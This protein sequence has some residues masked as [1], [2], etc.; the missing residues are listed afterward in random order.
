MP[1]TPLPE[2]V[3]RLHSITDF[4]DPRL[5]PYRNM[6]LQ[7]DHLGE[8]LFVAEGEKVVRRMLESRHEVVSVLVPPSWQA[9]YEP[10][11]EARPEAVDLFVAP[12]NVLSQLTGFVLFQGV[13]GIGRAP[14][15]ATLDE[16]LA[17]PR[18]RLFAAVDAVTNAVNV[19]LVLRNAV[20]LGV[21]ALIVGETSAH[22]YLR[23][24][25]RSCMGAL[26]K[27]PYLL[28]TDLASTLGQLRAAGVACIAAHPHTDEVVLPDARLDR[29]C[30]IV[31]G[32][33]GEGIRAPV[34]TACDQ[35][36]VVPMQAGVDSL[37]VGNA[38]A[39]F[40]YEAWRQRR[41]QAPSPTDPTVP[42]HP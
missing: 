41:L 24:S 33:E 6:R 8:G 19:G 17:L 12:K 11:L 7:V 26:F 10:L 34:R 14:R 27:V 2:P 15:P 40:F 1:N 29:D 31:L 3:L 21:Q 23:R 32:S 20:A 16:L 35:R 18:P 5:A 9:E 37:N 42:R 36:V 39:V 4:D 13:L 25:V 30:C 22:P 38:A 28:S